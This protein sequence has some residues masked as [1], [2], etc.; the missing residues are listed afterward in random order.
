[1]FESQIRTFKNDVKDQKLWISLDET[2]EFLGRYVVHFLVKT[3]NEQFLGPIYMLAC[4][5]LQKVND[6][7]ICEFVIECL[8]DLWG[9]QFQNKLHNV[10]LFST[11]SVAY[12]LKAGKLL[13][14]TLPNMKHFACMAHALHRLTETIQS[15]YSDVD[16]L[17][18]NVK[19]K[20][21]KSF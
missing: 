6:R 10:L 1:M 19:K 8:R 20:T 13:K 17:I 5:S 4:K 15:N 3:L 21:F 7:S 12:M 11:D 14:K 16:T 18:N 9:D 2:T